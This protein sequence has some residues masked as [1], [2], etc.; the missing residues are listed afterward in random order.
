MLSGK[1]KAL[2]LVGG[3]LLAT[4]TISPLALVARPVLAM[5]SPAVIATVDLEQVF[6]SMSAKS[7]ADKSLEA[8][9]AQLQSEQDALRGE[10]DRLREE[11]G[12]LAPGTS[13]YQK[14]FETWQLKTL[15]YQ[16]KVEHN[17][18]QLDKKKGIALRN[19]YIK[20][21]TEVRAMAQEKGIDIVMLDDSIV[22][23]EVGSEADVSRQISA[24]RSLYCNP[25]LDVTLEL[26][27]RMNRTT[28][29]P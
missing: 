15:E 26:I 8:L 13:A 14:K 4:L 27:D 22:E 25:E 3:V 24:R 11:L 21:K 5:L 6:N 7:D 23:L 29:Q 12:G 1:T 28:G 18:L 2:W 17:K 10:I 20:I 16:A 9:A 19:L